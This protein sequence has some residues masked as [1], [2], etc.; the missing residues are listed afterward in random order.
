MPVCFNCPWQLIHALGMDLDGSGAER[1][2]CMNS[3]LSLIV[4]GCYC[5][6]L[7]GETEET[8]SGLPHV[9]VVSCHSQLWIFC[10]GTMNNDAMHSMSVCIKGC[11]RQLPEECTRLSRWPAYAWEYYVTFVSSGACSQL[12]SLAKSTQCIGM[13]HK[14]MGCNWQNVVRIFDFVLH[15]LKSCLQI[16]S[17]RRH[18]TCPK[19]RI[20]TLPTMHVQRQASFH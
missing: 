11:S 8:G 16:K 12:S 9:H 7:S 5:S 15:L 17:A 3:T 2:M 1:H 10:I 19:L 6:T 4:T 14:D 13:G 18:S 20:C